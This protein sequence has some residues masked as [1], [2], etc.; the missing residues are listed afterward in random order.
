VKLEVVPL[1]FHVKLVA[2][3]KL[4]RTILETVR[5]RFGDRFKINLK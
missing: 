2:K 1:W 5:D 4:L 3:Q